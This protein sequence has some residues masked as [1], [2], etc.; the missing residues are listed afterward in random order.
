MIT[1][2]LQVKHWVGILRRSGWNINTIDDKS[3][4]AMLD[5]FGVL[6]RIEP[7]G[8]DE[9][10]ELWFRI[11]RPTIEEYIDYHNDDDNP[12]DNTPAETLKEWYAEEYP[13]EDVWF[14][15]CSLHHHDYYG[16]FLD[17]T[18]IL[19]IGDPNARGYEIDASEF[20]EWMKEQVVA[21]VSDV[22]AGTY[23]EDV[24]SLLPVKYRTGSVARK[25]Y[26]DINPDLRNSFR[27]GLSDKEID[28]F[29]RSCEEKPTESE[30][31]PAMTARIFY[32]ACGIC[33]D[34]VDYDGHRY[35]FFTESEEEKKRYGDGLTPKEKYY[36]YA[37][38]RDDNLKA[39]PMDDPEA[40]LDWK[41]EKG[42]HEMNGHHPWEIRT[43]GSIS[44]S[45]HLFPQRDKESGK[46][47]FLLSGNAASSSH[48]IVKYFLA[49]R[50]ANIPVVLDDAKRIAARYLETDRLGI[51]PHNVYSFG[52]VDVS[53]YFN[54]RSI[55]DGINLSPEEHGNEVA[56]KATWTP[57]KVVTLKD[58]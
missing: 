21:V 1:N 24:A 43:S 5:L 33:Y 7:V 36:T 9:R 8:D 38:G 11:E 56:K 51:F 26:W 44:H 58:H 2:A 23:N 28:K 22:K 3:Q 55:I 40:Y 46:W 30:L 31:I 34:S 20:I 32:E 50:H 52:R 45:I 4:T 54:D 47:Y 25:D 42:V 49:L 10:K 39:V 12:E 41:S 13:D 18:Y 14:P 37:D 27:N 29:V 6:N 53:Y 35:M 15:F 17:N 48:E 19:G 57:E 16:I